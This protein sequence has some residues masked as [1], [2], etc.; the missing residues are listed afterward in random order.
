M[1]SEL[2]EGKAAATGPGG[3]RLAFYRSL[4]SPPAPGGSPRRAQRAR[5][6]SREPRASISGATAKRARALRLARAPH[7]RGGGCPAPRVPSPPPAPRGLLLK[8]GEAECALAKPSVAPALSLGML[9]RSEKPGAE[10]YCR[11]RA[12][13]RALTPIGTQ[14]V[15]VD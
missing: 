5:W 15:V 6:S 9:Q 2:A 13:S 1:L 10:G 7:T 8:P 12:P 14:E 3:A 4:R 11:S